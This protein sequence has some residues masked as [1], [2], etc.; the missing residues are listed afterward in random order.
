MTAMGVTQFVVGKRVRREGT[1]REGREGK[2]KGVDGRKEG[3]KEGKR[4]DRSAHD[5]NWE[6]QN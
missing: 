4:G 3:R 5:S 1:G 2:E 6:S